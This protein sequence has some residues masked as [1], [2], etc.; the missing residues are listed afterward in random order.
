MF[1]IHLLRYFNGYLRFTVS[2]G[3]IERFINLCARNGIHIWDGKRSENAFSACVRAKEYKELRPLAKRAGVRLRIEQKSG[4]PFV[5]KRY[6]YR[7]GVLAGCLCFLLF[8]FVMSNFVWEIQIHGLE[9]VS[10]QEVLD[11][12][13]R[14]GVKE[15]AFIPKLNTRIIESQMLLDLPHLSWVAINIKGSTAV[16]EV[17]ERTM[18]PE[19]IDVDTPCNIIASKTGQIESIQV[20][21]GMQL[22]QKGEPVLQGEMLV[23]GVITDSKNRSQ[24][25][26]ARA[27]VMAKVPEQNTIRVPLQ[28]QRVIKT[29]EV[30]TRN[31]LK[32]FSLEIPLFLAGG[33]DGTYERQV[34]YEP[35]RIFSM[36]LPLKL[37]RET[38]EMVRVER[39]LLTEEEA[40]KQA[41]ELAAEYESGIEKGAEILEKKSVAKV[42]GEEL[43]Y[44]TDYLLLEDIALEQEIATD[45]LQ[46][47]A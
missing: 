42:E 13:H 20:F 38:N 17:K 47:G 30:I 5:K 16:V 35:L 32:I 36:A 24:L 22:F 43:V 15:S 9:T 14:N 27:V 2:D 11:S 31:Y 26:H 23:S 10:E 19:L 7:Y 45:S 1:L 28:Q 37:K 29:G 3:F 21:E 34:E 6:H 40:L 18:P 41:Q 4:A 44:T 46:Q 25:K 8:I 39:L 12:L 33:L